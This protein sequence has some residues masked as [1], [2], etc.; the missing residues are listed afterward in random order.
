MIVYHQAYDLYHS[1][2]RM[3]QLLTHFKRNEYVELDRLSIWDLY[4]LF[5]EK[6]YSIKLTRDEGDVRKLINHY[7][8]KKEKPYE[9]LI[10]N[11]KMF[12]KIKP[13]Q[14]S[15]IKCLASMG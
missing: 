11:R 7:V 1:V 5:P 2:Y 8:S 9:L 4:L 6:I 15:A 10:Y 13:Y 3:L 12:E 14:I